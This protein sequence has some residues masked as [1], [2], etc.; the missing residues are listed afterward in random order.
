[1]SNNSSKYF[2]DILSAID[3][4]DGNFLED[5]SAYVSVYPISDNKIVVE[6]EYTDPSNDDEVIE[7]KSFTLEWTNPE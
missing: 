4:N 5:I 3:D 1:M 7:T 6:L 2:T